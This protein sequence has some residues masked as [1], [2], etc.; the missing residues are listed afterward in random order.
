[1]AH[2]LSALPVVIYFA[3]ISNFEYEW[4]DR[5]ESMIANYVIWLLL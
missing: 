2:I 3:A 1:M 4:S 5:V